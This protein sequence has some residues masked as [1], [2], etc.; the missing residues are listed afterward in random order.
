MYLPAMVWRF[1]A[2]TYMIYLAIV[3]LEELF[4]HSGYAKLP[5]NFVV[6]GIARRMDVHCQHRGGN[7]GTW[8]VVDWVMGT[9][10]GREAVDDLVDEA[11]EGDLGGKVSRQAGR[12]VKKVEKVVNGRRRTRAR[13][14]D[15]DE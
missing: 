6:G 12:N 13:G 2:L 8:G 15:S 10:L 11:R 3:S 1:H 7:F 9:G 14:S 4:A 5:T